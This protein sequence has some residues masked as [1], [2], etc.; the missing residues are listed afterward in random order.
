MLALPL[1]EKKNGL[2][3]KIDT[4]DIWISQTIEEQSEFDQNLSR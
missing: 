2:H 1:R 4:S 3:I